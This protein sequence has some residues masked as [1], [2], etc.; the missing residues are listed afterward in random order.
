MRSFARR[1]CR[2]VNGMILFSLFTPKWFSITKSDFP[3]VWRNRNVILYSWFD[4]YIFRECHEW[5]KN[6][7]TQTEWL[8][9]E[10]YCALYVWIC[11]QCIHLIQKSKTID[12]LKAIYWDSKS[13]RRELSL[14]M[15]FAVAFCRPLLADVGRY[16]QIHGRWHG[17]V[18][19][20]RSL[21][22]LLW[23]HTL[24]EGGNG[25]LSFNFIDR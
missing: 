9:I 21:D 5:M 8:V 19:E 16:R 2:S 12:D 13:I 3:F 7:W 4:I 22:I 15:R 24:V 10:I 11:V 25:V 20:K 17:V 23:V 14:R 18:V 6:V 1:G